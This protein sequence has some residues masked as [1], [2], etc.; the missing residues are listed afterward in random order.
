[1]KP[2]FAHQAAPLI[3]D[4]VRE[5]NVRSA[6]A[7]IRNGEYMGAK[8]FDLH[9]SCLDDE[10]KTEEAISQIVKCTDKP[11][12]ALNYNERL[13]YSKFETTEEE[14]IGLLLMAAR[15]GVSAIDIQG[16]TFDL[17]SKTAYY[18]DKSYSFAKNNP[19]EV[20]TDK[21]VIEKQMELIERMHHEGTEVLLSTHTGIFMSADEVVDMALF[22]EKRNP[23]L[24]KIVTICENEDQLAEN[25]KTVIKLKN[26]VKTRFTYHCAGKAGKLSRIINPALGSYLVFAINRFSESSSYEQL[27]LKTAVEVLGKLKAI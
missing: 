23:D 15:A 2:T 14:R 3:V 4:V 5:R 27:D 8:G 24:L 10:Y 12:L 22:L 9:L 25:F 6:M 19:K 11:I 7:C 21:N 26:E 18:G 1:M 16:Y 20:V 17:K 13:D